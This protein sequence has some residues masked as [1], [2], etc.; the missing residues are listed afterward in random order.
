[1]ESWTIYARP[2]DFPDV[3]FVVRN[4]IITPGAMVPGGAVAFCD[5]LEQARHVIPEGLTRFERNPDDDPVIVES[6]L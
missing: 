3:P 6:W 4:W 1:M 2:A 5:S